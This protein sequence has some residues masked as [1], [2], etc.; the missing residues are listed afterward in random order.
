MTQGELIRKILQI[1]EVPTLSKILEDIIE[2]DKESQYKRDMQTSLNYYKNNN[3]ILTGVISQ[4]NV[5]GTI[6]EQYWREK[7]KIT[8]NFL[9]Q[10]IDEKVDYLLGKP[11][12]ITSENEQLIERMNLKSSDLQQTAEYTRLFGK[13]F[14]YIYVNENGELKYTLMDTRELIPIYEKGKLVNM[15]RYYKSY[16]NNTPFLKVEFYD[17]N[18]FLTFHETKNGLV[19][20]QDNINNI[21]IETG[22]I[23]IQNS[24]SYYVDTDRYGN[25]LRKRNFNQ[26]PFIEF[27]SNFTATPQL[28]SIKVYIDNIDILLSD[29]SV[30]IK[31]FKEIYLQ[32]S[33]FG[34]HF[35]DQKKVSEFFEV[36]REYKALLVD[37]QGSAEIKTIE[38]PY[39]AKNW[40]ITTLENIM[41]RIANSPRKQMEE[42]LGNLSGTALK[43][44][45][46]PLRQSVSKMAISIAEGIQNYSLFASQFYNLKGD[47][48]VTFN[49]N[50]MTN[51]LETIQAL[52]MS[53]GII[54]KQTIL[55]NH[56]YVEDV[57]KELERLNNE[58]NID[59]FGA[60]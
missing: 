53:Q 18:G 24:I 28:N 57:E 60:E 26:I 44:L 21:N 20:E 31:T 36:F 6:S 42:K 39:E 32:I 14:W 48:S 30:D 54:S 34:G 27:K 16:N 9:S 2:E 58:I 25:V 59:T 51:D 56:P 13:A 15:I 22:K 52:T 46:N 5:K 7:L 41:Y 35:G 4:K 1:K 37:E 29:A 23:D 3:D 38:I 8:N 19:C 12:S 50:E 47:V 40:L 17:E 11:P 33:G 49:Y 45:Q 43:I 10:I 55:E